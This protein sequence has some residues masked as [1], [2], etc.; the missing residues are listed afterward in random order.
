MK[1]AKCHLKYRNWSSYFIFPAEM[2]RIRRNETITHFSTYT[3][4]YNINSK[5]EE[6]TVQYG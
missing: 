2:G 6:E 5:L 4:A 3:T 1:T